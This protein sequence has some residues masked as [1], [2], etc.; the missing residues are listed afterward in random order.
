RPG[1]EPSRVRRSTVAEQLDPLGRTV[2]TFEYGSKATQRAHLAAD[3]NYVSHI[4]TR[5]RPRP[6]TGS[7]YAVPEHCPACC[8]LE[9]RDVLAHADVAPRIADHDALFTSVDGE[10]LST[11]RCRT[12]VGDVMRRAGIARVHAALAAQRRQQHAD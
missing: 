3:T 7:V 11:D 1:Q 5:E 2:V 9:L 10:P 12:I 6:P 8:V 4:C